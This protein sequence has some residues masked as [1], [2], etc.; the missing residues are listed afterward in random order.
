MAPGVLGEQLSTTSSESIP[1][2]I[3][4]F[5]L[6]AMQACKRTLS[7]LRAPVDQGEIL[8]D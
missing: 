3:S 8:A 2:A 1:L 7:L 5:V 4:E 6:K